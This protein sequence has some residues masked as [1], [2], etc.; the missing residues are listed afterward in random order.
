MAPDQIEDPLADATDA[1]RTEGYTVQRPL[2]AVLLVEGKF[3]NPER[4]AL[5]A[6]GEAGDAAMGA[7]AISRE[8]DWTLVA[9]SRPDLVTITQR[10]TAPARWRHRR[11]PP[12]MRPDAQ[13]FLEGGASPHDIVTTP[14]HRPTDAAREVLTQLGIESPEPPGWV[15]PP[16]PPVPVVTAPPVKAV[17]VRAPRAPKP[18]VVRKPEPVTNVCP[19]C[20]MAIPATG[21]CDNCG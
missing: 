11:I 8:N 12:A 7:W 18:A 20:F 6:A 1:L 21:I 13:T 4:I 19:R 10:G 9:W 2:D 14:K 3:L 5:R 17:R 15:P 16:P